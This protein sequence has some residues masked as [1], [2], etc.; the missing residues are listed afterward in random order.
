MIGGNDA[1]WLFAHRLNLTT[2][3]ADFADSG[4][5]GHLRSTPWHE[6]HVC[7]NLTLFRCGGAT[8]RALPRSFF[9]SELICAVPAL[10]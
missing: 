5:S 1:E 7:R 6:N 8:V 3:Y 9:G 2:D 4:N 10:L